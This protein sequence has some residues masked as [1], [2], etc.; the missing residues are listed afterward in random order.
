LTYWSDPSLSLM[1]CSAQLTSTELV[2]GGRPGG[3]KADS[4]PTAVEW[5]AVL[6]AAK[7]HLIAAEARISAR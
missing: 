4:G 2:A 5:A 1:I 6:V 7:S 3:D